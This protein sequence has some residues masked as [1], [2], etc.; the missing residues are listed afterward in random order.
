[1]NDNGQIVGVVFA[2]S[3]IQSN[4]GYAL[5]MPQVYPDLVAGEHRTAA[6]ST[7]A[8]AA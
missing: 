1:M 2:A 8:C 6:V 7:Q 3:T 4:V 5:T